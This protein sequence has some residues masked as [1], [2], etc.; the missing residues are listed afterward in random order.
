[1]KDFTRPKFAPE[2]KLDSHGWPVGSCIHTC[3]NEGAAI[4][5]ETRVWWGYGVRIE[6]DK[7][8][9]FGHVLSRYRLSYARSYERKGK[10]AFATEEA[11]KAFPTLP[12]G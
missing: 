2:V 5:V 1:M 8:P 7:L 6:G 10:M 12:I 3:A 11:H 4:T 9:L